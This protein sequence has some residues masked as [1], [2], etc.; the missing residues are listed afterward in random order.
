MTKFHIFATMTTLLTLTS[1]ETLNITELS[2]L[3]IDPPASLSTEKII[4]GL[5]EAL[6]T[7]TDSAVK[8]LSQK[9]GFS[10]NDLFRVK[11]PKKLTKVTDTMKKIGLGFLVDNFENKMNEAAERATASAGPV[12]FEAI[13]QMK[14]T[15]AKNILYGE[16]TAATD[17][18]K[19]TTSG[20]LIQLYKPIIEK[21]MK[22]VG[23]VKIYNDLMSK[24]DAIQIKT[25]ILSRKLCNRQSIKRNVFLLSGRRK[26]DS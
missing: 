17:Y 13:K 22:E 14:F 15:D 25:K 6:A 18:L 8:Q 9:E 12:F 26:K 23:V 19:K 7:G 16:K 21:S 4:D 1:C 3:I 11:I 2:S 24:Y 5:K 20:K 10:K